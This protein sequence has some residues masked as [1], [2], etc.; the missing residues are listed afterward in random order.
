VGY[1]SDNPVIFDNDAVTESYF[2]EYFFA[3][4]SQGVID[5]RG[6][7]TTNSWNEQGECREG[8]VNADSSDRAHAIAV[9]RASGM[10]NLPGATSGAGMSLRTPASGIIEH[11]DP[12]PADGAYLILSEVLGAQP[13]RPVVVVAGGQGTT[14]ASAYLLAQ[15]N[16][17]GQEFVDRL[18]VAWSMSFPSGQGSYNTWVDPWAAHVVFGRLRVVVYPYAYNAV[19]SVSKRELERLPFEPLRQALIDRDHGNGHPGS[20]EGDF[21]GAIPFTRSDYVQSYDTVT[22]QQGSI[23]CSRDGCQQ[24]NEEPV[25]VPGGDGRVIRVTSVASGVAPQQLGRWVDDAATYRN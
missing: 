9:A 13:D 15:Q 20:F 16:G 25:L 22:L 3:L 12:V 1:T 6:A 2:D 5:L 10:R 18:I 24:C 7:I 21:M 11:T 23:Q 8:S 19:A 4:A 17:Q 14:I